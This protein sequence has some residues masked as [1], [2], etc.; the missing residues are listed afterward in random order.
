MCRKSVVTAE[1]FL[2]AVMSCARYPNICSKTSGGKVLK[3]SGNCGSGFGSSHMVD[4]CDHKTREQG[5]LKENLL[6]YI[7]NT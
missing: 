6:F 1:T 4:Q 2:K 7:F 5:Y 3:D